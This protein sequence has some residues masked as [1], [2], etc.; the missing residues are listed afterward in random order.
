MGALRV[1]RGSRPGG[2][3]HPPAGRGRGVGRA[4]GRLQRPHQRPH[5]RVL[6]HPLPPQGARALRGRDPVRG[7]RRAPGL[8]L[9]GPP[10]PQGRVRHRNGGAPLPDRGLQHG[11]QGRGGAQGRPQTGDLRDH[12]PHVH[13][14]RLLRGGRLRDPAGPGGRPRARADA[15]GRAGARPLRARVRP[16]G[17][18]VQR[19]LLRGP[20]PALQDGPHRRARVRLRRHGEL[21]GHHLPG[22]PAAALPRHHLARGRGAHLRGH[23]ARDRAP[24]VRQP[25]HPLGLEIPLAERELRHLL[26]LRGRGPLPPRV[27]DLGPVPERHDRDRTGPRR[28]DRKPPDRDPG[29]RTPGHQHEHGPHHLQQGGEPPA[30]DRGVHRGGQ[31]PEGAAGV[32]ADVR[33][34]LRR[35]HPP[36][37]GLRG[38]RRPARERHGQELGRAA[39]PPAGDRAARGADARARAGA[40]H[41]SAQPL[42]P[43]L[44]DPGHPAA[45]RRA[46]GLSHHD[47][48]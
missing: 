16:Q 1:P 35:E 18:A 45:L 37:G 39:R 27:G 36:L 32:P 13:L 2:A 19:G 34:P 14:P 7:K 44:A 28:H 22:E 8:P 25:G 47:H 33:L 9:H 11:G 10:R 20:V 24:V 38:G 46:W 31:L 21:G 3:R 48:Y 5:G 4:R 26:R 29:R 17:A 6:P 43:A 23:R 40:L 12:P 42:G 41:V 30:P 15:P